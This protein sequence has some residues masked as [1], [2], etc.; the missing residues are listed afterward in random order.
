MTFNPSST[1]ELRERFTDVWD[2]LQ[3]VPERSHDPFR[4]P[5]FA[6]VDGD[7]AP[8]NRTVV[9]RAADLSRRMLTIYS[10]GAAEKCTA[11]RDNNQAAFCFWDAKKRIQVR[12]VG[13]TAISEGDQI[14]DDWSRQSPQAQSL[15]RVHPL[16]GQPI[17]SR[18]DPSYEGEHRFVRIDMF[19]DSVD[20]LW[21][22]RSGHERLHA[23]WT[24]GKWTLDW[25]VP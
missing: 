22:L 9:L 6:T 16:P 12:M 19:V 11:L 20:V 3:R 13:T 25:V 4:T 2:R 1:P 17:S 23:H 10:D 15:Y 7:G 14:L 5:T 18:S 8:Q 21:L 24:V